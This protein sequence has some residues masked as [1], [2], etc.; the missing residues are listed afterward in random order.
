MKRR[1]I[2]SFPLQLG[3]L[4]AVCGFTAAPYNAAA[5]TL[6]QAPFAP[7]ALP[8]APSATLTSAVTGTVVDSGGSV[9]PGATVRLLPALAP[10]SAAR[11]VTTGADG[12]F[13]FNNVPPGTVTLTVTD[14]DWATVTMQ[15]AIAPSSVITLPAIVFTMPTAHFEVSAITQH[16]AAELEVKKAEQQ[17]LLG[18][19]PNF[20]VVYNWNAPPIDTK[21]KF[22]LAT[23]FVI[24]PVTIGLNFAI[25]GASR[26]GGGYTTFGPGAKGYF[27]LVGTF[28]LDTV[29]GNELT[30]AIYPTIFHQ[31]PRYFWKGTGSVGSRI[32]YALSRAVICRGDNG[33][34]QP[35]Y[36]GILGSFSAGALSN[37]YYPA[38]DNKGATLTLENGLISIGSTAL[39]NIVQ[40]FVFKRFTPKSHKPKDVDQT[41]P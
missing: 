15:Q 21:Q 24:D 29:I 3:L 36:S 2:R 34:N 20:G 1:P 23:R 31:D 30:G 28:T 16:Q 26:A 19:L 9:I 10:E 5:Q 18:V 17:R 33:K 11:S 25:A 12:T 39:G 38:S 32:G 13:R 7:Q 41:A 22:E 35:S 6:P 8:Q 4:V 14:S 27:R 37:L 40:E